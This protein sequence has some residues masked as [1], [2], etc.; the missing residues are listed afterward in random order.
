MGCTSSSV[1]VSYDDNY[2]IT[3]RNTNVITEKDIAN[4]SMLV[5]NVGWTRKW[6]KF[7][8]ELCFAIALFSEDDFI[9]VKRNVKLLIKNSN[10]NKQVAIILMIWVS[11][12]SNVTELYENM[13]DM[14]RQHAVNNSL[15]TLEESAL[16]FES[17][18]KY[19]D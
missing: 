1:N 14:T 10:I 5:K 2:K 18:I 11:C 8:E 13:M 4:I 9:R 12:L 19:K 17:I 7:L 3:V 6:S 15:F 16:I